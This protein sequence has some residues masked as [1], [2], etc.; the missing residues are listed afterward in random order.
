LIKFK[1]L[2]YE[3]TK[4]EIIRI[5]G[6]PKII[7]PQYECGAYSESQ[8]GTPYQQLIYK[9][10]IFTGNEKE[11]YILQEITFDK[12]GDIFLEIDGHKLS[13]ATSKDR[14]I[15]LFVEKAKTYF[16]DNLYAE[17]IMLY[18]KDQDSAYIFTFEEG[19]LFK[20][21]YWSPC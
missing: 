6:T 18:P 7:D 17:E 12:K 9:S 15:E 11:K 13:N 4:D 3:S 8:P 5:F 20:I 16:D 14:F 2:S 21:Q 1:G 10:F 19:F